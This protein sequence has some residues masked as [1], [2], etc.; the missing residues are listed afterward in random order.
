MW[1]TLNAVTGRSKARQDPVCDVSEVSSSFNSIV[2]DPIRPDTLQIPHSPCTRTSVS[3][4]TPT[5]C[6]AV[7]RLLATIDPDKATGS[8]EI[9][10]RLL[11]ACSDIVA[12]H[13]CDLFN[14]SLHSGRLP[15]PFKHALVKPLYKAGDPT[16]AT[17]YRPVSLLPIVAK[18]LEKVVHCQLTRFLA[19]N[20]VLPTTQFA[21]RTNHC[22]EDALVLLTEKILHAKD[23]RLASGVC[24]LDMS[25]A[26]DKVKHDILVRDLFEVGLH[27]TALQWFADY[28]EGRT[29]Q[30]QIAGSI[31]V[32][33][34]CSCGVPQGSV[35]GP[36]LF[37]I[38]T[39]HV[40]TI[41][42]PSLS[43][44][45]ADDIA[46]RFSHPD[47]LEV[48]RVLTTS[49]TGI[50][51]HLQE[52]NLILNTSK[53]HVLRISGQDITVKCRGNLLP[54]V[55]H[56]KYLG[57]TIDEHV[58]FD[59]HVNNAVKKASQKVGALWRARRCLT[60]KSREQYVKSVVMPDLLYGSV[61]F[62]G[63]LRQDQRS[64]LQVQQNRAARAVF[65]LP[66]RT[67][68][69]SLLARLQLYGI[70]ELHKQKTLIMIWR[71]SNGRASNALQALLEHPS[72]RTTRAQR[73]LGLRVPK[74]ASKA[75]HDRPTARGPFYGTPCHPTCVVLPSTTSSNK[76]A[77]RSVLLAVAPATEHYM[78]L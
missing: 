24:L 51:N 29:Q 5:T 25:K 26:F 37:N 9:P 17:N 40:P 53:S 64:R 20:D 6:P 67:S 74:S 75:G 72:T 41:A 49:T 11:R 52:R 23:A 61:A 31:G 22:T 13:L 50:A 39:R 10:G 45:F 3:A 47:C 19:A 57:I 66:P 35:L 12:P 70:E 43:V 44:Q 8:D 69:Q 4:L 62:S 68:A 2:T 28:L 56:A 63:C 7:Q 42:S 48:S 77:S 36:V 32:S 1:S 15:K 30:V 65:G 76:P 58:R 34:T 59:E 46:L 55:P 33:G 21:Y 60:R 27:G 14:A 18:L 78:N 16:V 38:Y 71:C 54:A 73:S